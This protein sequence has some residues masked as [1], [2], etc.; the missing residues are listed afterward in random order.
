MWPNPQ[1]AADLATFTEEIPKENFIFLCSVLLTSQLGV[2]QF[3]FFQMAL[4][5]YHRFT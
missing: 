3:N 4:L 1:E 5:K 2:I